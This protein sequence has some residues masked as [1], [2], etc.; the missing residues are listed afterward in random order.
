MFACASAA[1][2]IKSMYCRD[3]AFVLAVIVADGMQHIVET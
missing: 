2:C 1:T 3:A